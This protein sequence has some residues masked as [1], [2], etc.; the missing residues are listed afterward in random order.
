VIWG[1][2]KI[3]IRAFETNSFMSLSD[4]VMVVVSK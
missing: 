1:E 3:D 4:E 2:D